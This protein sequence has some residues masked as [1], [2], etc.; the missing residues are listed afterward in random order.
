MKPPDYRE[1]FDL[2]GTTVTIRTMQPADR[3]M[4]AEFV[5]GL[6]QRSRYLRFHYTLKQLPEDMLER[7]TN[8]N[9]PDEMA[10]IATIPD[11]D[12]QSQIGVARY[13]RVAESDRAEFA[14][15]VAD[16][17]QRRGIGT[18]LLAGLIHFTRQAGL[19]HLEAIVLPDNA[20][21]LSLA[22]RLGFKVEQKQDDSRTI[23]LG[24]GLEEN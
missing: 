1:A 17:W 10:L 7:F 15:V 22:E 4:E 5:R 24:K 8:V 23:D 6:S 16:A 9:Y 3:N 21:M 20:D 12:T 11:G 19:R 18:R 14:I 2:D 13:V